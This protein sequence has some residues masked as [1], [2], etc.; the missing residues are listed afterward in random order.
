[1][2]GVVDVVSSIV[3]PKDGPGLLRRSNTA[4]NPMFALA[5][6]MLGFGRDLLPNSGLLENRSGFE[7]EMGC[8]SWSSPKPSEAYLQEQ[9][10]RQEM[11]E[12]VAAGYAEGLTNITP[13]HFAKWQK[14]PEVPL[15]EPKSIKFRVNPSNVSWAMRQRSVEQKSKAGTVL[16]VWNDNVRKTYFDEPVITIKFESG[17]ILPARGAFGTPGSIPPGL[18]NFYEF[19]SLVDEVKVLDDGRANLCY[20]NYNSLIFPQITLWGFWTPNGVSF[21]DDATNHAQVNSWTAAFTVYRSN[22]EIGRAIETINQSIVDGSLAGESLKKVYSERISWT[23][24]NKRSET[25]G[26]LKDTTNTG[27]IS[28]QIS[29]RDSASASRATI[30]AASQRIVSRSSTALAGAVGAAVSGVPNTPRAS[31]GGMNS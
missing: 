10:D 28:G 27:L 21:V 24:A 14:D 20:I 5:G 23:Y 2:A 1:M 19:L 6:N 13:E 9:A 16:H 26:V 30:E 18:N 31:G 29:P 4:D 25:F 11:R 22:P 17:N 12:R 7:W 3:S 15:P 8:I